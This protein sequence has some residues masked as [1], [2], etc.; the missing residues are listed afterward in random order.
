MADYRYIATD[1]RSGVG[2]GDLPLS[3]VQWSE[4]LGGGGDVSGSLDLATL[5][6][7]GQRLTDQFLTASTP[8]RVR[9]WVER[10]G[11]LVW[12]GFIW[13]R[14]RPRGSTGL[15][16]IVAT[17]TY[18]FFDRIRLTDAKAYT[19]VDQFDVVRDLIGWA[20]AR[21][22]GDIGVALGT[23]TSGVLI[24]REPLAWGYERK[25]IGELID[26]LASADNGFDLAI[27]PAYV[28]DVPTDTLRLYSPR[29]GR[30][31]EQAGIVFFAAGARGGN[32][33][34]WEVQEDGT[35]AATTV[36]GVGAGE[37]ESMLLTVATRTDLIDAGYPLAETA[38]T[39]KSISDPATLLG[40]TVAEV[41]RLG[42]TPLQW[43]ID[44][45]PDD[46]STPFGAWQVGDDALIRIDDDWRFPAGING[47]PGLEA[48]QRIMGQ[49]VTVSDDGGPDGVTLRLGPARG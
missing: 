27:E 29:R 2:L 10:D 22:G 1:A 46:L 32:L 48:A 16:Q 19:A 13:R 20:L 44:V 11:H 35:E 17:S 21:P 37:G 47:E 30:R 41:E 3:G 45:D 18:S 33:I 28:A 9:L 39:Y 38:I 24:T 8:R 15:I 6:S 23:E 5:T 42:D 4:E 43:S 34:D 36:W 49:T 14:T 25:V 12:S 26:E 40:L 7:T 31:I